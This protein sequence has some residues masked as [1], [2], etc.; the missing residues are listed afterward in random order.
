MYSNRYII[1]YSTILVIVVAT[2]LTLVSIGLKPK[3]DYNRK[4]EKMQN[5]LASVHIETTPKNA[6]E[7][8]NKYIIEQF[9]IDY[10]NVK[11]ENFLAFE[12]NVEK[13]SKLPA[14]KRKLP[15]FVHKTDDGQIKYIIPM[16]GKG[17]WG[18]IWGYISLNEDKNTIYGAFFDHKGETPG[19]GAEISTIEF[20]NQFKN[21]KLFDEKGNFV[22]VKTVKGGAIDVDAHAVDAISGGTI[23]CNG[24]NKMMVDEL[25]PYEMFLKSKN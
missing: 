11:Q 2:L 17:L 24:L 15:V 1:I 23:T 18:P 25:K 3:Q 14:E 16:Y 19:L 13:E 8:F 20:Q 7:Y 10:K 6:Q 4:V 9:V 5:V 21:K 12:V 22:S